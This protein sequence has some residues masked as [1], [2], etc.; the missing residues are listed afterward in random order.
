MKYLVFMFS[1]II[2]GII[3]ALEWPTYKKAYQ[4]T[5]SSNSEI[6]R[7]KAIFEENLAKIK[8]N[9]EN[10]EKNLTT[11]KL[12]VNEFSDMSFEEFSYIYLMKN[13]NSFKVNPLKISV[14]PDK[15]S[16]HNLSST[17]TIYLHMSIGEQCLDL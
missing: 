9:N 10:F 2:F 7:R 14:K 5:Y 6:K 12:G 15:I 3:H 16:Q 1:I 11:Y 4:K 17:N 13:F 8:E